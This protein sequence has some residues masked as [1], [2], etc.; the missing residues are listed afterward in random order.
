MLETVLIVVLGVV[1]VGLIAY[2]AKN[3]STVDAEVEAIVTELPDSIENII[4]AAA[5]IGADFAESIDLDGQIK[6]YMQDYADKAEAKLALAVET[7]AMFIETELAAR[8]L[9]INV[10]QELIIRYING[11][12]FQNRDVYTTE[13]EVK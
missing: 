10:P 1:V 2:I 3:R 7:A 5:K 9:N 12:V 13:G 4:R 6:I 11:F 8:G